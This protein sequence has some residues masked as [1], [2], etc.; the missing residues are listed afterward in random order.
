[1][2]QRRMP[3]LEAQQQPTLE[4][5]AGLTAGQAKAELVAAALTMKR[6]AVLWSDIERQGIPRGGRQGAESWSEPSSVLRPS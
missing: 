6:Q 4:R 2:D 3:D 5:I 1:M